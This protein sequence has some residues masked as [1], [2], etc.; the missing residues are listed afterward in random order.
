MISRFIKADGRQ[1]YPAEGP[2]DVINVGAAVSAQFLD[3]VKSQIKPGGILIAPVNAGFYQQFAVY[4][5][6]DEGKTFSILPV[7]YIPLTSEDAQL[8]R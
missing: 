5:N 2:Y 6:D 8:Q 3:E 1:G 7:G 4:I